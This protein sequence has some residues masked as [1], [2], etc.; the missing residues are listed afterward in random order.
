[1]AYGD[2]KDLQRRK[3]SDKVLRNKTF[4]IGKNPK[5]DAYQRGLVSMVYNFFDKKSS[6]LKDKSVT[7]SGIKNEIKQKKNELLAEALY[8]SIIRKFKKEKHIHLLKTIFG[9]LI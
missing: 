2:F 6:S 3:V 7:G 8:Q 5:Y 1:M 9:M 4:N